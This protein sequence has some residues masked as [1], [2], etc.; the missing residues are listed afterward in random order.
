M[1]KAAVFSQINQEEGRG[2]NLVILPLRRAPAVMAA[3][4]NSCTQMIHLGVV[5]KHLSLRVCIY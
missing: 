3:V 5:I 4:V 2:V 1:H